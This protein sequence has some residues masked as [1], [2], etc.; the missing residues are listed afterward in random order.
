[1]QYHIIGPEPNLRNQFLT[2]LFSQVPRV[3]LKKT[4]LLITKL[5]EKLD[6]QATQ[7]L[8]KS[9]YF[10]LVTSQCE[11]VTEISLVPIKMLDRE[12]SGITETNY[13][14]PS[15]QKTT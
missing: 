6:K 9:L 13:Q 2:I 3:E 1:M 4:M 12:L 10:E 8:G 14:R 7:L 15:V 11:V 5:T